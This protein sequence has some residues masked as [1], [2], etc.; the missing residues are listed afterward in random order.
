MLLC[1]WLIRSG[2]VVRT[3]AADAAAPVPVRPAGAI[4][5]IVLLCALTMLIDFSAYLIRPFFSV[6]WEQVSGSSDQLV[7]GLVFA[8]PGAVGLAALFVNQ[9]LRQGHRRLPDQ[10]LANLLLGTAGLVLQA[11]PAEWAILAGR[12]LYGWALFQLIVKLGVLLSSLAAGALVQRYGIVAITFVIGAAGFAVTA[13]LDRLL[14]GLDRHAS[15][16]AEP[17]ASLEANHAG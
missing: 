9:R 12:V 1:I 15:P 4:R 13:L 7:S 8:I 5:R 2:R 3:A 17:V 11:T 14:F 16:A 10:L 6:Y